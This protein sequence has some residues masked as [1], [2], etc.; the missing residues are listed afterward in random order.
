MRMTLSK[1]GVHRPASENTS[2][3][4]EEKND[5][6]SKEVGEAEQIKDIERVMDFKHIP[7]HISTAQW[8]PSCI[9]D[10]SILVGEIEPKLHLTQ[11]NQ[12]SNLATIVMLDFM[13][14][15]RLMSL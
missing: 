9:G 15:I 2:D 1:R 13:S 10:K 4:V 7:A 12:K 5:L 11:W 3:H 8:L 14:T 6:S